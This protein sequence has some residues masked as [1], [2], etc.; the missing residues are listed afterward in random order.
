MTGRVIT[1][2][3][4][5]K[6]QHA[7]E[8]RDGKVRK[9]IF[10]E[11]VRLCEEALRAEL[12]IHEALAT[13]KVSGE[14][15]ARGLLAEIMERGA[16]VS[17]ISDQLMNYI[18]ATKA[19]QGVI[20]VA[21]RPAT[22]KEILEESLAA[23]PLVVV[24]HGMNNP[25]NAGAILRTAEA[26]GATGLIATTGTTYLFAPKALRGAMGSSFRL[27]LWLGADFSEALAWCR[28]RGITTVATAAAA[29]KNFSEIDWTTPRAII[30]GPEAMGLTREEIGAADESVRIP[31][32]RPVESLNAAVA[33]GIIL[34]EA[35]RQRKASMKTEGGGMK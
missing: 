2:R 18:S 26:A 35:V 15:R 3:S 12:E 32:Q 13:E 10:V 22:G 28:R 21:R 16:Q 27:P 1:S 11:G 20:L 24:V 5:Q 29:A 33:C 17:L 34:Y 23:T 8:V 6:I 25:S 7:R 4:N 19:T 14:E 9:E 31:M 30:I